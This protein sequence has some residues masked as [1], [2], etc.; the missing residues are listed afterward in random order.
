MKKSRMFII[1]LI[2]IV[3]IA[4]ISIILKKF[5][6]TEYYITLLI[7]DEEYGITF[8][9]SY[10]VYLNDSSCGKAYIEYDEELKTYKV[11]AKLIKRGYY[12]AG[13]TTLI[14][15]D[16]KGNKSIFDVNFWLGVQ[17]P[18][19]GLA[20]NYVEIVPNRVN[21]N[22]LLIGWKT[23]YSEIKEGTECTTVLAELR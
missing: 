20:S 3:V 11:S 10:K 12:T 8:D 18:D 7:S 13:I 4:T 15:D 21:T 17:N 19:G 16:L 6:T 23:I 2:F 22:K 5:N 1:I 9:N 14:I